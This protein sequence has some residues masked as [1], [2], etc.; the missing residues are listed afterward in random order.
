MND[1][2]LPEKFLSSIWK[3][4]SFN[5]RITM[6]DGKLIEI[7]DPGNENKESDG[8]DFK[9][10]R[11]KIGNITFMGD[12]EID[13][14]HSDWKTHGHIYNKK[15]NKVILHVIFSDDRQHSYVVSRDGRKIPTIGIDSLVSTEVKS[16]IQNAILQE[17]EERLYKIPCFKLNGEIEERFKLEYIKK[18]GVVRFQKKCSRII[19]RLK[20]L[21]FL[22]ELNLKEPVIQ[23]DLDE[24]FTQRTFT[25]EDFSD[26]EIW[27]QVFYESIFE[28]LGYTNNKDIMKKMAQTADITFL[29]NYCSKENLND[30]LESVFFNI[31]G[32]LPLNGRYS[33]EDTTAYI[34][35]LKEN[36]DRIKKN[37]DNKIFKSAQWNLAK[38]RPPN[39]P[40]IRIAGGIKIL[41]KLLKEDLIKK[42][43][44]QFEKS[45]ENKMAARFLRDQ[46]IVKGEG[47]WHKHFVFDEKSKTSINYFVGISRA[48]DMIVNVV[49]PFASVY[50]E[51]FGK[52]E[53]TD[54]I[55]RFYL[56]FNQKSDN[57]LVNDIARSL[58]IESSQ[59]KSVYHQGMI[60]L[61]RNYCS[62]NK[63]LKCEIGKRIFN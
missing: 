29:K 47:Y 33:G 30:D 42:I 60:N 35:E 21:V 4:Q 44:M 27:E 34:R 36:W 13:N 45:G 54:R 15:Y 3:N 23:Y 52:K 12:I 48:D 17:R 16:S 6:P 32:L 28:A 51:I 1:Q 56:S 55:F 59:E 46:L 41:I 53:I 11:I 57:R 22:K 58:I 14:S 61:Y 19:Q 50:F 2:K 62:Q 43:L 10:A 38:L 25:Y 8:P 18:L 37:Y 20:E 24:K 63:C 26:T 40:A 9:N 39:F 7:I 31:S 5:K 49:L